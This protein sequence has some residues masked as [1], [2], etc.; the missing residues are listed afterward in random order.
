M[1]EQMNMVYVVEGMSCGH[2]ASSVHEEVA[3]LDGIDDVTVDLG[4]G[5]LEVSGNDVSDEA[6]AAAVEAAGYQVATRVPG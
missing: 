5:R 4:S 1:S 3:G 6:V 2:C